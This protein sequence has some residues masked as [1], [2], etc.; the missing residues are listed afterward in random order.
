MSSSI[1]YIRHISLR[2]RVGERE[3]GGSARFHHLIGFFSPSGLR[4]S[5]DLRRP[6]DGRDAADDG[7]P[8]RHDQVQ[9]ARWQIC[10]VARWAA[11]EGPSLAIRISCDI[12][13][14]SVRQRLCERDRGPLEFLISRRYFAIVE[15]AT[16]VVPFPR[17]AVCHVASYCSN[18]G[19]NLFL[20]R[21]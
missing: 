13:Q 18:V 6:D 1:C 20:Q 16:E 15:M 11:V 12:S 8:F 7:R 10:A 9:R 19:L 3:G 5:I 21:F 14:I 17:E 2:Y 4:E